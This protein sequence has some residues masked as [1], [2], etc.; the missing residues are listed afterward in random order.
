MG[1][2][3]H[4]AYGVAAGV[5]SVADAVPYIRDTLAGRTRPHRGAWLVWSVIATIA[6]IAHAAGGGTWGLFMLAVQ[7]VL[8]S[9]TCALAFRYPSTPM[10]LGERLMLAIAAGG[11]IGWICIDSPVLA[12]AGVIVAD[13]MAF[14]VVVPKAWRDPWSE[15]AATY[16]LASLA[17]LLTTLAVSSRSVELLAY[18]MYFF[19]ANLALG[20]VLFVGRR[21]QPER[22][23]FSTQRTIDLERC[24]GGAD[25]PAA[26]FGG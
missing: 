20:L 12:T 7:S 2:D 6:C 5:V 16:W 21:R 1:A 23:E 22:P 18:P 10:S 8:V 13:A 9:V 11:V 25:D 19:M 26:I 24:S 17:G 4:V 15:T 3:L 14:A